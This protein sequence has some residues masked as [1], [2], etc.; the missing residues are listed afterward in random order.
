M[1]ICCLPPNPQLAN[2]LQSFGK[3][4]I[5]AMT[6]RISLDPHLDHDCFIIAPQDPP[7]KDSDRLITVKGDDDME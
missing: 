6:S 1:T 4:W 3:L 2:M 7:M 5:I